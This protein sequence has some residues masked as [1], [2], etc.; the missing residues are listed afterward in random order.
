[1]KKWILL[2]LSALLLASCQ[3]LGSSSPVKSFVKG[4]EIAY[5]DFS[6]PGSFEEGTYQDATIRLEINDGAYHIDNAEGDSELW[7]GQWGDTLKNVVIDV[8]ARQT[9]EA[10]GTMYGV[11][12]RAR[13]TVGQVASLQDKDLETLASENSLSSG[14]LIASAAETLTAAEATAEATSEATSEATA[15]ATSEATAEAT[16]ESTS[17]ATAEATS[18]AT[19][20]ATSEATAEATAEATPSL[21][22]NPN[23]GDGYLFLVRGDGNFAI[24]RSRGRSITPLVDWTANS[25]IKPGPAENRI[26]AVCMDDYLAMYANGT[27]LGDATDDTYSQGQVALADAGSTRLGVQVSFD[28]LSVSEANPQ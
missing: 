16:A 4:D 23:N 2:T 27:F 7:Y 20:E 6:E 15:E 14:E 24:M 1:M 18:D 9:T 17:E 22:I 21:T 12:C 28:N 5:Y 25:A 8:E 10:T 11:M 13:G 19:A 3:S 26:R